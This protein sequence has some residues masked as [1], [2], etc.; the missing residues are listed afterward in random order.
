MPQFRSIFSW[1]RN[2]GLERGSWQV[3]L[4]IVAGFAFALNEAA[5][6]LYTNTT[7]AVH[8]GSVAKAEE[9]K[10]TDRS[11]LLRTV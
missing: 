5:T 8:Y 9:S 1:T 3:L 10:A 6:Q 11:R 2:G 4:V 7:V